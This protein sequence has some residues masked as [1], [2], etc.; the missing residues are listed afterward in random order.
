MQGSGYADTAAPT[1]PRNLDE[2]TRRL[3]QSE[4]AR[5][6][7]G[8]GVRRALRGQPPLGVAPVEPGRHQL[9]AGSIFRDHLNRS[10]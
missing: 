3:E 4:V 2:A 6:L 5:E 10:Q 1:L 9:G 8:G 7:L